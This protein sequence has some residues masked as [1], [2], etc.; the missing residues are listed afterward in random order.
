M[1]GAGCLKTIQLRWRRV[2]DRFVHR[3]PAVTVVAASCSAPVELHEAQIDFDPEGKNGGVCADLDVQHR[4][5]A[6]M[7][8]VF[9]V[10]AP[11]EPRPP[12]QCQE[13]FREPSSCVRIA[14]ICRCSEAMDCLATAVLL[15]Q[16][17]DGARVD[18]LEKDATYCLRVIG[19]LREQTAGGAPTCATADCACGPWEGA[20]AD[21][22]VLRVCG[23]S[24]YVGV[25]NESIAINHWTCRSLQGG[26]PAERDFETCAGVPVPSR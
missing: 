13:C 20:D 1:R 23:H 26:P 7:L 15:D 14:Q 24:E 4:I 6:V 25:D 16:A 5:D 11:A 17:L 9:L 3:L 18:D 22:D 12:Y 21:R 19:A 8:E 2:M 10:P